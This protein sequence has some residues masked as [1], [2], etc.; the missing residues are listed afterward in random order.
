MNGSSISIHIKKATIHVA[1]ESL[2]GGQ[3]IDLSASELIKPTNAERFELVLDGNAVTDHSTG[4][5]WAKD[6]SDDDLEWDQGS[7]YCRDFRLGGFDDW[8][9]ASL[10]ERFNI[11]DFHRHEPALPPQ[12]KGRGSYEWTGEPTNWTRGKAGSSRSFWVV[13]LYG[14]NLYYYGADGRARVRPVRRAVPA[15]Q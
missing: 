3:I 6:V 10:H 13:Y 2:A 14:G 4:L 12:F 9:Y 15:G 1:R 11:T 8:R 5:M 7:Q